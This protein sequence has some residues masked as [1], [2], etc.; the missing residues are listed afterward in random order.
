MLY[1]VVLYI[2]SIEIV[3][4]ETPCILVESLL[5]SV[6]PNV[7]GV[8]VVEIRQGQKAVRSVCVPTDLSYI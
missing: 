4:L 1:V 8:Y 7:A 6:K 5:G 2:S 3:S